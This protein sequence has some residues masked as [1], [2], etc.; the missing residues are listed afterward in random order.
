MNANDHGPLLPGL[1]I[2]VELVPDASNWLGKAGA[3]G[4]TEMSV[5]AFEALAAALPLSTTDC[6]RGDCCHGGSSPTPYNAR[7]CVTPK[8][9]S[10]LGF[11][12]SHKL[13]KSAQRSPQFLAGGGGV[14]AEK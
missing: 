7:F 12:V 10:E 13:E 5:L 9:T 4:Q 1:G 11:L 14:N 2:N 3:E 8:I 6:F